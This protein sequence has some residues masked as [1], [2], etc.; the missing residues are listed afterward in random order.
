M[1]A[2]KRRQSQMLRT[3]LRFWQELCLKDSEENR[4]LR[5]ELRKYTSQQVVAWIKSGEELC[6]PEDGWPHDPNFEPLIRA[7]PNPH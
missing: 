7:L 6:W 4:L 2:R 1:K 5:I 3:K